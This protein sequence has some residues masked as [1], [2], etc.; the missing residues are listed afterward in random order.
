MRDRAGG[1]HDASTVPLLVGRRD[2]HL[3]PVL[4]CATPPSRAAIETKATAAGFSGKHVPFGV[5]EMRLHA[6]Q[7]LAALAIAA[8]C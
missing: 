7:W 3:F 5:N 8:A 1:V 4:I 6:R 2:V